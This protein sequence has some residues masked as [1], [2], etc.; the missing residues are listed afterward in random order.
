MS[1]LM[2]Y[3]LLVRN[4]GEN[5]MRESRENTSS[6]YGDVVVGLDPEEIAKGFSFPGFCLMNPDN[7]GNFQ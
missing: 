4:I 1:F 6:K 2:L 5:I 3:L 7:I